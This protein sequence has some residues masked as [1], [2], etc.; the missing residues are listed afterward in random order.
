M[1]TETDSGALVCP[2]QSSELGLP[3][4][5]GPQTYSC[6]RVAELVR[7]ETDLESSAASG[8]SR[9]LNTVCYPS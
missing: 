3:L 1:F 9:A 6:S 5:L 2:I 8:A 7:T 4:E